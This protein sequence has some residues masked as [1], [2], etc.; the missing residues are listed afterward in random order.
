MK[1]YHYVPKKNTVFQDGIL[2]ISKND[3]NLKTYFKRANSDNKEDVIAW[4]E[5]TFPGRSKSI[6]CLT[7]PIKWHSND[8]VLKQIVQN[9]EL[10]SFELNDLIEDGLVEAI[11]CKAGSQANGIN[12]QF[13]LI[14]SEQIDTSPLPWHKCNSSRGLIYGVIR[15]YLIVL[16]DGLIPP[17]YLSKED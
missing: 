16:K 8:I 6:S 14:D 13:F 12:E 11:W 9:S 7:E 1:L 15:H 10:F 3:T 4:L 5:K 17:Q 2:S